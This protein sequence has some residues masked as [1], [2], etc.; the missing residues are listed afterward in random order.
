MS[1]GITL[2]NDEAAFL[3]NRTDRVARPL[4]SFSPSAL[5]AS[6]QRLLPAQA[7][8]DLC[9]A[10][11]GGLDS[12]ALLHAL[13]SAPYPSTRPRLR[14]IHIDHGLHEHSARWDSHCAAAA[15]ELNIE[16]V[17]RPVQVAPDPEAGIESAARSVRYA[18]FRELLRPG[19]SLLTAHHADDQ[20]ETVL[21]ALARG[22][23]VTGMAGMPACQPFGAGWH[24]RP[25]LEF[26]RADIES[27]ACDA[28]LS[29]ISDPS[30]EDRHFSRNF[31]R[32]DIVPVLRGRWPSIAAAAVRTASHLAEG[33]VLLDQLAQ[34]DLSAAARGPCLKVEVLA[35]MESARRRNLL[36]HWV[37]QHGA[38]PPSTRKLAAL[39]H[40]MLAAQEDRLP[41]VDWDGFEVRRHRGLL[42]AGK[43]QQPAELPRLDWDWRQPLRLPHGLGWLRTECLAQGGLAQSLLPPRVTVDFRQGGEMLRPAGRQHH[44]SLKK[45]LQDAGILPWWRDR[46]PLIR[47]GTALAAVGDLWVA[48]E[49]AANDREPGLR[50]VWAEQ[51]RIRAMD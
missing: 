28:G 21:L 16:Y 6:V 4:M 8:G 26:S 51:P 32:H 11:S 7:T 45:L 9:V 18:V 41:V 46:V 50:V 1:P 40:D 38:R 35:T 25:M 49:F 13:A 31:L 47:I 42:Y 33:S 43:S 30:N 44:C 23:G 14:A 12:S 17:S 34:I 5:W 24:L 27:W 3:I 39:E 15:A 29:A 20:L 2:R 37:R 19:E 22:A 48:E 10:F 36:R